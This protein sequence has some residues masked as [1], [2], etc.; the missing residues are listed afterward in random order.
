M[1]SKELM[2]KYLKNK[3]R[4]EA[5]Y[6]MSALICRYWKYIHQNYRKN[7]KFATEEDCYDWLIEAIITILK[8][9]PWD[10]EN[11]PL[12][13]DEFAVDKSFHKALTA[14]KD[15][16]Y[17]Y[18]MSQKRKTNTEALHLEDDESMN[19][20]PPRQLTSDPIEELFL[21]PNLLIQRYY[22]KKLFFELLLVAVSIYNNEMT[23]VRAMSMVDYNF[24]KLIE[25]QY[26]LGSELSKYYS[27]IFSKFSRYQIDVRIKK[28]LPVL[29]RD[30]LFFSEEQ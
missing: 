16:Y 24:C 28:A 15:N 8:Y 23:N 29:H 4:Q 2:E 21:L 13:K 1:S 18:V 22:E 17:R 20:D 30:I 19:W 11:N 25:K 6:Y 9:H 27:D 14:R 5:D 26:R 3:E 10:N 7:H 12:Y